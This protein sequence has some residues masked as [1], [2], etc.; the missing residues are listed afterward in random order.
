MFLHFYS[1]LPGP[2]APVV[3][4]LPAGRTS[5]LLE[6]SGAGGGADTRTEGDAYSP[7]T[8]GGSTRCTLM[9]GN[10]TFLAEGG[11][12]GHYEATESQRHDGPDG[13]AHILGDDTLV[14][15]A[16]ALPGQGGRGAGQPY[17]W[18][19]NGEHG[20]YAQNGGTGGLVRGA[21]SL[22]KAAC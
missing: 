18:S 1:C 10:V 13:L 19:S 6:V 2:G 7:P 21:L 11:G 17:V 5:L 3:L 12:A 9:P 14:R 4:P 15:D 22:R 8:A 16:F 20:M